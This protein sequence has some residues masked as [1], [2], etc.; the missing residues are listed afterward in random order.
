ME[1]VISKVLINQDNDLAERYI[2]MHQNRN[3]FDPQQPPQELRKEMVNFITSEYTVLVNSGGIFTDINKINK[4]LNSI[5]LVTLT[6][7]TINGLP[8]PLTQSE[9]KAANEL[10][11][12]TKNEVL[13]VFHDGNLDAKVRLNEDLFIV[14][15]RKKTNGCFSFQQ[16]LN[17]YPYPKLQKNQFIVALE[18]KLE[19]GF[20]MVA[21]SKEGKKALSFTYTGSY[22]YNKSSE[23]FIEQDNVKCEKIQNKLIANAVSGSGVSF[24]IEQRP[25]SGTVVCLYRVFNSVKE[26]HDFI[27]E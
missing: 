11:A 24:F 10:L 15:E 16:L 12:L 3:P 2:I 17:K 7:D 13:S 5:T 20:T 25:I 6:A 1:Y 14:I 9:L 22:I 26:V 27:S 4:Q 8:Q 19:I 18:R 23:P 21:L